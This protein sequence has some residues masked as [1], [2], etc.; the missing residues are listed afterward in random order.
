ML[1]QNAATFVSDAL[2]SVSE[3]F[4]QQLA[5]LIAHALR[6]MRTLTL[7]GDC[8]HQR[9]SPHNCRIVKVTERRHIDDVGENASLLRLVIDLLVYLRVRG[10]R[11]HQVE[12]IEIA[13][14]ILALVPHYATAE[15]FTN[16]HCGRGIN[17]RH[18]RPS[19]Q[20][21]GDL[22]RTYLPGAYHQTAPALEF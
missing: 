15:E 16:R 2:H 18:M 7:G 3:I 11:D 21:P 20:Q 8:D 22:L 13:G 6:Q 10:R 1:T 17:D 12:T 14:L 9:A 5:D 19:I 4:R